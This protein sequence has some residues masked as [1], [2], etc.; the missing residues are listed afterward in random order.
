MSF[1]LLDSKPHLD[2]NGV[3]CFARRSS[4]VYLITTNREHP[5]FTLQAKFDNIHILSHDTTLDFADAF[6]VLKEDYGIERMTI[7]SSGTLNAH[8]LQ[9]K[10]I[11][12]VSLVVAPCL[13]GGR[14]TQSLIG[15]ES[16]H[17][18]DDLHLI[19]ALMLTRCDVLANSYIHLRYAVI[20]DTVIGE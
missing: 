6:R 10:L 15:G 14:A 8:L 7:Q 3:E 1:V 9:A 5:A 19:K 11:D 20:K 16:V 12:H 13:I 18:E 2:R 4:Q 17:S